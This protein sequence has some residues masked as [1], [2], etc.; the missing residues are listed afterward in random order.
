MY[1]DIK[2]NS[3]YI[4]IVFYIVFYGN[5]FGDTI[6]NNE[7]QNPNSTIVDFTFN[8]KN[9]VP[10]NSPVDSY[11]KIIYEIEK[12][13]ALIPR[14]F[15]TFNCQN[16]TYG[17]EYC[18]DALAPADEY[19]DYDD[20]FSVVEV[21]N[22]VDYTDKITTTNIVYSNP[23]SVLQERQHLV[24]GGSAMSRHNYYT[25]WVN[26]SATMEILYFSDEYNTGYKQYRIESFCSSGVLVSGQCKT[27]TTIIQCPSGYT[28]TTGSEVEQGEC[29]KTISYTYY[30]YLC[31]D[32]QNTQGE[33][34]TPAVSTTYETKTD[35]NTTTVNDTLLDD[36]L[37]SAT[38]PSN[39]CKRQGF[40]CN[41]NFR[42]PAWVDGQW[43]CSVWNC[44]HN[45][46]CGYAACLSP[47]TPSTTNFMDYVMHPIESLFY[48][49]KIGGVSCVEQ[50]E[51]NDGISTSY[52]VD[53]F[54][55]GSKI[56][57]ITTYNATVT[58]STV[59]NGQWTRVYGDPDTWGDCNSIGAEQYTD[60]GSGGDSQFLVRCEGTTQVITTYNCPNG[61]TLNGT[62]CNRIDEI[63]P[64]D[65]IETV[66][67]E[68]SK[69]EC[70]KLKDTYSYYTYQCKDDSW[71]LINN[72]TD[73]GCLDD[74]FGGCISFGLQTGNCKRSL[75]NCEDIDENIK[76]CIDLFCDLASYNNISY[77]EQEGCSQGFGV[78]EENGNCY[79]KECP[80]GTSE[81]NDGECYDE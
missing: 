24:G 62:V 64:E 15:T 14:Y 20:G 29:K 17:N 72:P 50:F 34:Y 67:S 43:K 40:T 28:E 21:G 60:D 35:P 39:N 22:V 5:V 2:K 46:Q 70:K 9:D 4:L 63:C 57:S 78:Y 51:Y 31:K 76:T 80:Q 71:T 36:T 52:S 73:P 30:E 65:Y 61:G 54:D 59:G 38:P 7:L 48:R 49:E 26:V 75:N 25:D 68:T 69:G 37:G 6:N 53:V 66:G 74:T 42:T 33:N 77:C 12:V 44:N 3:I 41:S 16:D 79:L 10:E 11:E 45:S 8:N 23:I 13:V 81:G 19:W 27:T 1:L 56:N 58:T 55:Y 18:P 47:A 32:E